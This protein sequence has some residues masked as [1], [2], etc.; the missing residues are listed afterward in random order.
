MQLI[1]TFAGNPLATWAT[2]AKGVK[3]ET[4]SKL[5]KRRVMSL[6]VIEEAGRKRPLGEA[7][8]AFAGVINQLSAKD[9][10]HAQVIDAL[11]RRQ[12]EL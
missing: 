7:L 10:D 8:A 5:R 11:R 12:G 6:M 1:C 4:K 2:K 3:A 9:N